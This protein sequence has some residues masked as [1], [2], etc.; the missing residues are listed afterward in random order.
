MGIFSRL[1][2]VGEAKANQLLDKMEKPEL[3]LEQAI[4]DQEKQ[5]RES[6]EKVQTVIAT[7]RQTK[8]LLERE[9]S[10]K[11]NWE[12]KAQLALKSGNEELA[13][14]GFDSIRRT[15]WEN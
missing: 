4:K 9:R 13:N 1:F 7:E 12:N 8:A 14:Q 6:K 5:I 15:R 3:M 2:K 10:E 11:S